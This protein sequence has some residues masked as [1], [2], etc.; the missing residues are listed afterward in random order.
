MADRPDRMYRND[1]PVDPH[2]ASEEFLYRRCRQADVH[3]ERLLPYAI[4]F[5]PDWSVN[6]SKYSEP[7]DVLY[8]SYLDWGV[9]SFQVQD[10]PPHMV[11]GGGILFEFK[12]EH[13]PE[14]DN[15][16]HSEVRTFKNG[17]HERKAELPNLIKKEFRQLLSERA[18]VVTPPKA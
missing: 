9:A 14:D 6:R 12:A 16:A 15:Y 1:R 7:E 18:R 2:F 4:R 10:I 3:G 13:V 8:P 17:V 11:S 5:Y